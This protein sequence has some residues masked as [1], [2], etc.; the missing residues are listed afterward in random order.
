MRFNYIEIENYKSFWKN[1]IIR[2][3]S[4]FNIFLGANNSGKTT[5]L[6]VI[7]LDKNLNEP[8][9]SIQNIINYGDKELKN[10]RFKAS[11]ST[12][13]QELSRVVGKTP[14]Y[15]PVVSGMNTHDQYRNLFDKIISGR[16]FDLNFEFDR[17]SLELQFKYPEG[18]SQ[19]TIITQSD[20]I[21]AFTF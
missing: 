1:Q 5:A 12:N 20:N 2:F 15:I 14:L 7:D 17:R 11:I 13:L 8:H 21:V 10:S 3:E 19:K 6:E 18:F 9:K 16:E 4:G